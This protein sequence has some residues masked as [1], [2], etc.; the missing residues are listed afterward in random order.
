VRAAVDQLV[1]SGEDSVL[2]THRPVLPALYDALGI[3]RERQATGEL[4]VV[5]HRKG[6]VRAV[7]RHLG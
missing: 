6:R 2:C 4:V 3:A 7:E 1:H 5:H